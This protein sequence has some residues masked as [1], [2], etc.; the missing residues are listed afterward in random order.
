MSHVLGA[1]RHLRRHRGAVLDVRPEAQRRF[2]DDVEAR[3]ADSIW[4]RGGCRSWY[5][6]GAGRNVALWPGSIPAY[7]RG[8][9]RLRL[10]DYETAPQ[11]RA[12][13]SSK[14]GGSASNHSL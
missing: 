8:A 1:L 13:S 12:G 14:V 4:T 6:D 7:R 3:M 10:S 9:A 5:L 11:N 2:L